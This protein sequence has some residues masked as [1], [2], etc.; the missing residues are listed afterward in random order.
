MY[1]EVRMNKPLRGPG[2]PP[3]HEFMYTSTVF[4]QREGSAPPD[5]IGRPSTSDDYEKAGLVPPDPYEPGEWP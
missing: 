4:E 2:A 5:N 3:V 1:E